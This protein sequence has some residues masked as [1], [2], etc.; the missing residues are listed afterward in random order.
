MRPVF[1]R[2]AGL[3]SRFSAA[4]ELVLFFLLREY[5]SH[6]FPLASDPLGRS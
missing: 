5:A 6:D 2:M 4:I 3:D 1:I